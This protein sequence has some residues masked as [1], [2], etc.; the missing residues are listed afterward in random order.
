[1]MRFMPPRP[2]ISRGEISKDQLKTR[3]IVEETNKTLRKK[4]IADIQ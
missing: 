2:L 3:E 4:K 1:M